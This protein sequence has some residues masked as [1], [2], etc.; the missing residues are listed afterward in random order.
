MS[1][2]TKRAQMIRKGQVLGIPRQNLYGQACVFRT[3]LQVG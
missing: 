3:L 1:F 2:L